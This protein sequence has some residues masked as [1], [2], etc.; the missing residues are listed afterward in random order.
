MPGIRLKGTDVFHSIT[1]GE[2]GGAQVS[3]NL[4]FLHSQGPTVCQFPAPAPPAL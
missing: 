2:A 1:L 4:N 3:A